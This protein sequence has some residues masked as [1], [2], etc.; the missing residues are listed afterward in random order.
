MLAKDKYNGRGRFLLHILNLIIIIGLIYG[1][2]R[3]YIHFFPAASTLK[4]SDSTGKY[5]IIF[6]LPED[7]QYENNVV[8]I[9]LNHQR[10]AFSIIF[11][12]HSDINFIN[13]WDNVFA[14]PEVEDIIID[15]YNWRKIEGITNFEGEYTKQ[16]FISTDINDTRIVGSFLGEASNE[17]DL[18]FCQS[19][20]NKIKSSLEL[21]F[22]HLELNEE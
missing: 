18:Q 19:G 13:E 8:Y 5:N 4:F 1:G 6:E 21:Y 10:C 12:N 3:A 16:I 7:W 11:G 20:F 15:D 9:E 22:N 14:F 17:E 2:Y